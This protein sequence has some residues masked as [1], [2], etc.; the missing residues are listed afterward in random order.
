[1]GIMNLRDLEYVVAVAEESHFGR[2]SERCNV[3]Q[4][5]LSGQIKKLEDQLGVALFE[6]TNRR[7]A[8]TPIGVDVVE[9][10]KRLL[11]IA[12]EIK[13]SAA[14]YADPLAGSLRLGVIPTIGPYLLPDILKPLK[15]ALPKVQ[16]TL[17][18]DQTANLERRLCNGDI[19]AAITATDVQETG[20]SE[21]PLYD[22]PFRVALPEGHALEQSKEIDV[23]RIDTSELLLL[24]DGHCL[25]DQVAKLCGLARAANARGVDT[26]ASSLETIVGLVAAGAGV[27]FLPASALDDNGA[28]RRGV[29]IRMATNKA[30]SRK[31]RLIYRDTY[32]K[33]QVLA[34]VSSVVAGHLPH[35]VVSLAL[36]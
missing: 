22:E 11:M 23:T 30:A 24:K 16:L 21:I 5:A 13:L 28:S 17:C 33:R 12:E 32:P 2:A 10:A 27:T 4:P 9:K 29:A 18:E 1:M 15:L 3:S 14:A 36:D 31:V 25:S 7:V 34:A 20:L 8:V 35:G 26:Q 6:R 19:D